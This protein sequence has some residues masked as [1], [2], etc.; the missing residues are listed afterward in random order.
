MAPLPLDF[1]DADAVMPVRSWC[2]RP[3]ATAMATDR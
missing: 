1:I 3:H 2:A